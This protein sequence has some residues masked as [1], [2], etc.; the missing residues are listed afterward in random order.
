[1]KAIVLMIFTFSR[2]VGVITPAQYA[3]TQVTG[4]CGSLQRIESATRMAM[5][6]YPELVGRE[7]SLT[8]SEGV[9]GA[10]SSPVDARRFLIVVDKPQW[11]PPKDS[12]TSIQQE[13][14]DATQLAGLHLPVYLEFNFIPPAQLKTTTYRLSC[15]PLDFSNTAPTQGREARAEVDKHPEWSDAEMLKA[16]R[17]HGMRYGPGKKRMSFD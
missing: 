15:H 12:L 6:I 16:A 1:M 13:K 2:L 14:N 10:L 4:S 8:F 11:H 9:T 5:V 7:L 17:A 3:E